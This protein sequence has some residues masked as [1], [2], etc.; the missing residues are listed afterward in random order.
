MSKTVFRKVLNFLSPSTPELIAFFLS[1]SGECWSD[2]DAPRRYNGLGSTDKCFRHGNETCT[3]SE[4][5]VCTGGQETNY[6]FELL[7]KWNDPSTLVLTFRFQPRSQALFPFPALPRGPGKGKEPGNEVVQS[8]CTPFFVRILKG[9]S[10]GR[11]NW[12]H[13]NVSRLVTHCVNQKMS[14]DKH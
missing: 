13:G 6:V 3:S 5:S 1:P 8:N 7:R 14:R 10:E 11:K 2:A 12:S 4:P 9:D